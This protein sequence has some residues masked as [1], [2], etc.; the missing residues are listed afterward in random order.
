M[1]P[2]TNTVL[3]QLRQWRKDGRT[4]QLQAGTPLHTLEHCEME[5]Q[6]KKQLKR[7]RTASNRLIK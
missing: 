5:R 2:Y 6:T 7:G 1:K 4:G 3:Q